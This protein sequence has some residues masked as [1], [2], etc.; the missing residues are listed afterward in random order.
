MLGRVTI[1]RGEFRQG[2][3]SLNYT[4]SGQGRPVVLIHGLSGSKRWWR[5]NVQ[6]LS[7]AFTVYVLDLSGYGTARR[8]PALGV[9]AA[10]DLVAAWLQAEHL[11]DVALVGHSMGGQIA[12]HVALRLPEQVGALVLVGA[13]GL[14]VST[15]LRRMAQLPRAA[16]VSR[17]D[18]LPRILLDAARA[19]PRNLWSSTVDLLRDSVRDLLPLVKARTLIVW[20]ALDPLVPV[21]FAS[22]LHEAIPGAALRVFP[23]AGHVVMVDAAED[24]NREVLA[25]L[26]ATVSVPDGR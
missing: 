19:G 3:A 10:A 18:F 22:V 24:F 4:R 14:L 12:L 11:Q 25:F 7:R 20:G 23:R 8:Q 21:A 5:H 13:S 17:K 15:P 16:L 2:A 1:Q 6:A 9:R 26:R